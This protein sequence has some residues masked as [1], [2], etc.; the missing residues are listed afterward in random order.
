MTRKTDPAPGLNR[1]VRLWGGFLLGLAALAIAL[2]RPDR[3]PA[4]RPQQLPEATT[5]AGAAPLRLQTFRTAGGWGYAI[6][7]GNRCLI[8]QPFIPALP[9]N[10]G[11]AT[12]AKARRAGQWMA[13]KMVGSRKPP[14]VTRR[15]LD[16][17][18]VLD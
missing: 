9:G 8:H 11:F 12:E 4:P 18:G 5:P 3:P 2:G 1:S 15:E 7:A 16:S 14:A 13:R 6:Y 10:R 17:L